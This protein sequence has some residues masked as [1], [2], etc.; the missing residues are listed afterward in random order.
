MKTILEKKPPGIQE[1]KRIHMPAHD[2]DREHL[3][4]ELWHCTP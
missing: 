1:V 4:V 3:L 2:L